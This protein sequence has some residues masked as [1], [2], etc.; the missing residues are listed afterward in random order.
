MTEAAYYLCVISFLY[1]LKIAEKDRLKARSHSRSL[2]FLLFVYFFKKKLHSYQINPIFAAVKFLVLD[3]FFP[4]TNFT[5][6][7]SQN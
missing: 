5:N 3:T 6:T 7:F 2:F 4:L 1:K